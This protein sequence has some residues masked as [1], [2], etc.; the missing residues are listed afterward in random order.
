MI[1]QI[2]RFLLEVRLICGSG[3][4]CLQPLLADLLGNPENPSRKQIGRV[5]ARRRVRLAIG[6]QRFQF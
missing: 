2:R 6:D 1:Q 5:A 3:E 4:C